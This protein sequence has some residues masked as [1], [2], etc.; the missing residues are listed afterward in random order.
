[1]LINKKETGYSLVELLVVVAIIGLLAT[2]IIAAI[3]H[4]RSEAKDGAR[5]EALQQL[6]NASELY[7]LDN[8]GYPPSIG[9]VKQGSNTGLLANILPYYDVSEN[10]LFA[11]SEPS[12]FMYWRKDYRNASYPCMTVGGAEDV[13][14]YLKLSDPTDKQL[15]TI[16]NG[17]SFDQCVADIWDM[18]YVIR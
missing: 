7:Y 14:F 8:G 17:D 13:G 2:A 4:A 3:Q 15:A 12:L 6:S 10:K 5:I 1:M 16:T 9:W 18:N 11:S